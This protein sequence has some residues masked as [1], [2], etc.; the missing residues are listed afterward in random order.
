MDV[1]GDMLTAIR[2]ACEVR[3]ETVS[4]PASRLKEQI[5]KI[6]E[7]EGYIKRVERKRIGNHD[8]LVVL[9]KYTEEGRPVIRGLE[10]VSKPGRRFYAGYNEIPKVLSG[11]GH[12]IVSTS[13]G[14]MTD[15][16]ARRK[17]IGGELI[18]K[19]W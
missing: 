6:F 18:C 3:Y 7:R 2:N 14:I 10:R 13:E 5:L 8:Y 12:M 4:I 17:R 11:L 15:K 19:I 9:L 16:E 1:I